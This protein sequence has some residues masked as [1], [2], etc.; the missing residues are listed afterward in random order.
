M[1]DITTVNDHLV[2]LESELERLSKAT[3]EIAT[4]KEAASEVISASQ[5]MLSTL[6]Q[7]AADFQHLSESNKSVTRKI[8]EALDSI[9]KVDFPSRLDKLDNTVSAVNIG[10]QNLATS[11]HDLS[12]EFEGIE[13][14]LASLRHGLMVQRGIMFAISVLLVGGFVA[15]L[16]LR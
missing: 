5:S 12:Q 8:D 14:H 16:F 3:N 7:V 1:S 13:N 11:F 15:T 2:E 4:A 10:S 9:L 6:K